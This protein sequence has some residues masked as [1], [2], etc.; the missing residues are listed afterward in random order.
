LDE[1]LLLPGV[2]GDEL[3]LHR[4]DDHDVNK[5]FAIHGASRA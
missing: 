4:I 1:G 5:G 2:K 3:M